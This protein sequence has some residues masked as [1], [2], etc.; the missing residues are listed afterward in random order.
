MSV[1]LRPYQLAALDQIRALMRQGKRKVM[2]QLPTGAGKT[3]TGAA[4][5][6]AALGKN[7]KSLF[8]AHRKEL[9]DQTVRTFARIGVTSVGVI[10]AGDKRADRSQPIQIASIQTL[11]RRTFPEAQIVFIDEAHRSAAATYLKL[12]EQYPDAFFVGLSATPCRGDGKPLGTLFDAMVHGATYSALIAEGFIVEPMV[13]STPIMPDLS[14]VHTKGGDYDQKELEDAVN[15]SALIG[16]IVSEWTKRAQ[17]RRTVAFAVSV[18]HSRAIVAEFQAAEVKAEHL[19]GET[20]EPE[21][22][23]ILARLESGATTVVS[24]CAVL[25]EGWDMPACKCL[26]LARPT[27]SLVLFMQSAGRIL[28]PFGGEVP[29]ILDH[30]GNVDRHGMP[31]EDRDWSLESKPARKPGVAPQKACPECFAYIAIA[32]MVCPHCG[33][34]FEA[35]PVEPPEELQHVEL[36][37]RTLTGPDAELSFFGQLSRKAREKGYAP[38]WINYRFEEKFGHLPD[39]AWWLRIKAA[40][41]KDGDWQRTRAERP[42]QGSFTTW[43]AP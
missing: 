35:A 22:E 39:K 9:I 29:I 43:P 36:A 12:F 24:N 2:L 10:R 33:H 28:R 5:L 4:M 14:G 20:P 8:V 40:Y 26:I 6:T 41:R 7:S 21:R 3:L 31:H 38:G 15:R 34:E 23:A 25:C 30:G 16:N 32:L 42:P 19:D 27:K 18:A 11:V 1:T 17:G 37:L 13:Y